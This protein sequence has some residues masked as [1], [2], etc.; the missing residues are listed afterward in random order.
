[1][2]AEFRINANDG[3]EIQGYKWINTQNSE[4]K[5]VIQISHGMAEHILRYDDF[6][7]FLTANGFIVYG[8]NH[9]G[10]G[11]IA[12]IKGHFAEEDGFEKVVDDMKLITNRI[13]GEHPNLP[14]FILGHSMGS[15]LTRRYVQK[16][17]NT[18]AGIILSGTGDS[19]GVMGKIGLF[20]AKW[21][22]SRNG[23]TT[24]SPMM[25]KLVFGNFNKKLK[26]ARTPFDFLTRDAT[27]VDKYVADEHCGFVCT[28]GFF[29]DLISGI[30]TINQDGEILKM[31]VDLPAYL[32]AGNK[33]PIGNYGKDVQ[34]VFNKYRKLGMP[35]VSITL[36][37]GARHEILN[38]TNKEEVYQDILSWLHQQLGGKTS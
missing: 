23:A 10:H 9:R 32:I 11:P 7:N 2:P 30:E 15:F 31:T 21:S 16:Y 5:A 34:Q 18:L 20:I 33:D 19:Q 8:N 26:P 29:V 17:Q 38:E 27:I 4:H 36:Y 12:G 24:P 1:M 35:N 3:T 13:A 22:K 37:D 25:D 6:A 28:N 14:V